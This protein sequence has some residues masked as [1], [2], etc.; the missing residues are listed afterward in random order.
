M[1][2]QLSIFDTPEQE[3]SQARFNGSDYV[4]EF[5]D[6]RLRGQMKD[7]FELMKDGK[8][9]TLREIADITGHPEASISAQIR[10]LKKPRFGSHTVNKQPRGERERGL[11][12]YQLST[13]VEIQNKDKNIS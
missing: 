10:H 2:R 6:D 9:R 11:W 12:E 7:I 1:T 5:D 4:P 13:K 3:L 8:F